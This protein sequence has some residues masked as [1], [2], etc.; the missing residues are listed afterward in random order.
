MKYKNENFLKEWTVKKA[1]I[2]NIL[3][4]L[5]IAKQEGWTGI[6]IDVALGK[7][8]YPETLKEAFRQIKK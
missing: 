6:Y 5:Q 7:N 2:D 8:K 1:E 4:L 3:N